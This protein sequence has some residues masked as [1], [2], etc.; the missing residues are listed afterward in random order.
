M[1]MT[2]EKIGRYIIEGEIGSGGMGIVYEAVDPVLKRR[3][4]IKVMKPIYAANEDVRKRF[5]R[6][7]EAVAGLQHPNIVA[8]FDSGGGSDEDQPPF[9]AMEFIEG[10][11]LEQIRKEGVV[12][13]PFARKL[14]IIAKVA[15]GLD[16]AHSKNVIHRDIKPGNIRVGKDAVKILDFGVARLT[17]SSVMTQTGVFLGTF[18]YASPEH[19]GKEVDGRSDLFS[20]GVILYELLTDERPF[21]G[22]DYTALINQ[23]CIEPHPPL[24]DRLTGCDEDL[25][26]IV[27]KALAKKPEDRFQ[28]GIEMAE[29]IER[30][31]ETLPQR[32]QRFLERLSTMAEELQQLQTDFGHQA[33][34]AV[35]D[36]AEWMKALSTLMVD[37]EVTVAYDVNQMAPPQDYGEIIEL[38]QLYR[39][40]LDRLNERESELR[41]LSSLFEKSRKE[42]EKGEWSHCQKTVEEI[43]A[44]YPDNPVA[45]DR[46]KLCEERLSEVERID[47]YLE[48]ARQSLQEGR[49]EQALKRIEEVLKL[50]PEHPQAVQ[51]AQQAE[52]QKEVAELIAQA[53]Q[54]AQEKD[55]Q[56]TLEKA[57]AGLGKVPDQ[58][59]L[60]AL[61]EEAERGL[62]EE[63]EISELLGQAQRKL[64][65][66]DPEEAIK[67]ARKGL[68]LRPDHAALIRLVERARRRI[69]RRQRIQS[70]LDEAR[71]NEKSGRLAEALQ[72]A[73]QG[74]ELDADHPQLKEIRQR[75]L[76]E[77]E[78]REEASKLAAQGRAYFEEGRL[79]EAV[80]HLRGALKLTPDEKELEELVEQAIEQQRKHRQREELLQEATG[81]ADE[82]RWQ[83][84]LQAARKG[85]KVA[86]GF[87][88]LV[89][90]A[91]EAEAALERARQI[92]DLV[93]QAG[94]AMREER[95]QEALEAAQQALE[96]APQD[97]G[98]RPLGKETQDRI[99][100]ADS[101][102]AEARKGME[103]RQLQEAISNARQALQEEQF[104]GARSKALEAL[105]F[106]LKGSALGEEAK[107]LMAEARS[108][109]EQAETEMRRQ[110]LEA[111]LEKARKA[112]GEERF[113]D[114]QEAAGQALELAPE[115]SEASSLADKARE[116][117]ELR[118]RTESLLES[119]RQ[120]LQAQKPEKALQ[121]IAKGLD[122]DPRHA[123]LLEAGKEARALQQ[124][125]E[126]IKG[127][128]AKAQKA[129]QA[130]DFSLAMQ[131][132]DEV[133]AL[134]PDSAEARQI[135]EEAKKA[136]EEQERRKRLKECL[137]NARQ[138]EKADDLEACLASLNEAVQ[139]SAGDAKVQ[140][141]RDRI[142]LQ[143]KA[144]RLFSQAKFHARA[145]RHG[146]A[147]SL[148]NQ[149]LEIQPGHS[150]AH[151]LRRESRKQMAAR[152]RQ[153][154]SRLSYV[155]AGLVV[156][157]ALW[158][159]IPF[160][161]SESAGTDS[162][163][164]DL[165]AGPSLGRFYQVQPGESAESLPPEIASVFSTSSGPLAAGRVLAA[166]LPES[167]VQVGID[168]RPWAWIESIVRKDDKAPVQ[169][170]NE[171]ATPV[172][173][174]LPPGEYL[175]T[176]RHDTLGPG[177]LEMSVPDRNQFVFSVDHPSLN[178]KDNELEKLINK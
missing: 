15:R 27:D 107:E 100:E 25:V 173:I 4:A 67:T 149:L 111:F 90:L 26:A 13:L 73:E 20:L 153:W 106:D 82:G 160:I 124:R 89:D 113:Q 154:V 134:Q 93:Q 17:T 158:W 126:K 32:R 96:A 169:M 88:P 95:L 65:S 110:R 9:M 122:L 70:L 58:E 76:A 28:N 37:P 19:F 24:H 147:V 10:H 109:A 31:V 103:R 125:L 157:V 137:A 42:F 171:F 155:A 1:A 178:D 144:N 143:V 52:Q 75:C 21:P 146:K 16:H 130:K 140:E 74:L 177:Q 166:D 3:L 116:L 117:L 77:I 165:P 87:Q 64:E 145:G 98:G 35:S 80:D 63:K 175:L 102:I 131:A 97:S 11:D 45:L 138:A 66:E 22:P 161:A 34:A 55:W 112:L 127:L 60:A 142:G 47:G 86:P 57:Q 135:K 12:T 6:E 23:I 99:E 132:C 91:Q 5:L 133:L 14:K 105:E 51:L 152:R 114:A 104:E 123:A 49:P 151:K 71:Q 92:E 84:C 156:A 129:L 128:R 168:V 101:I 118:Q 170:E 81:L 62:E 30:Y 43:L 141:Y 2:P 121:E 44:D 94:L 33:L 148:L 163:S 41:R 108:V 115:H 40:R 78:K 136:Q 164:G 59:H 72:A 46:R 61:K 39:S 167:T 48:E 7:A 150:E 79:Q 119:A 172:T 53:R 29:A 54:A 36:D 68:E 8:I 38:C 162:G 139:W 176:F 174:P 85:L 83:G 69:E 56:R 159:V 120:A 18:F 50:Q